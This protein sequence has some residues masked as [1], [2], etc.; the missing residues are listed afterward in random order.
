[1]TARLR[2]DEPHRYM[3]AGDAARELG[4]S[5]RTISTWCAAGVLRTK[6]SRKSG[7][8]YNIVRSSVEQLKRER[9]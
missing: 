2:S 6:P 8:P 5:R 4:V 1:M 7:A 9:A 3:R